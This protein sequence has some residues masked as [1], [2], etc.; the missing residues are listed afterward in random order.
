MLLVD[1]ELDVVDAAVGTEEAENVLLRGVHRNVL[2]A[3]ESG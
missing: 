3:G 1:A 2:Y